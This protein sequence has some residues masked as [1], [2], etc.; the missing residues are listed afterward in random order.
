VKAI[1][2]FPM[3][4]TLFDL[5]SFLG[6]AIYYRCFIKNSASIAAPLTGILKGE[7]GKTSK[8][9]SKKININMT[10]E[11]KTTFKRLREI[12]ASEDVL[13]SYP[14]FKKPFNLTT[15]SSGYELGAVLSQDKRPITMKSR[16]LSDN[17]NNFA[18]NEREILAIVWAL[19]STRN[20]IYGVK[21]YTDHQPLTFAISDKNPN[22]KLKRWNGIIEDNL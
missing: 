1:K 14:D 15:D 13:L 22:A 2:E 8:Y 12:L 17:E 11:Q 9:R 18:T 3:P 7:N 4:K 5:R 10:E 21:V 20:Y 19:N 16:K 6:L